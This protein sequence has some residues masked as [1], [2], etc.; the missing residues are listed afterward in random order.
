M[1]GLES[2]MATDLDQYVAPR[3]KADQPLQEDI[4]ENKFE[5][6][7][8]TKDKEK[9]IH[10]IASDTFA[11][12]SEH[13]Y[14]EETPL[15]GDI[16]RAP[17]SSLGEDYEGH[18]VVHHT[19]TNNEK[20]IDDEPLLDEVYINRKTD[21]KDSIATKDM[22]GLESFMATDLDQC[23]AARFEA[24]QPQQEDIIEE[25]VEQV[26]LNKKEKYIH[27]ITSD[28]VVFGTEH[29]YFEETVTSG[30][31]NRT[32]H[33]SY[34]EDDE[35]LAVGSQINTDNEESTVD[36]PLLEEVYISRNNDGKAPTQAKDMSGLESF[37]AADLD[38]CPAR[39]FEAEQPE[40]EDIIEEHFEQIILTKDKKKDIHQI[41]S[42]EDVFGT[43]HKYFEETV[44][45]EDRKRT[46]YSSFGEDDEILVVGSQMNTDDEKIIVDRPLLEEVHM[47]RTTDNQRPTGVKGMSESFMATD[48]GQCLPTRFVAD[49]PQQEKIIEENDEKV[50]LTKDKEKYIHQ[51]TS[52]EVVFGAEHKYYKETVIS[53]DRNR[54]PCSSLGEDDEGLAV[55]PQM[56]T[57]DEGITVDEPLLE[58]HISRHSDGKA[59]TQAKDMSGLESFMATDLDQC[60]ATRFVADQ[61]QQERNIEEH[62]EHIILTKDKNKDIHQ[63]TS[64]EVLFGTEHKYFEETV[65][66]GEG[67]RTP[68]SSLGEDDELL[69]VGSQMSTDDEE[70]S[71]DEPIFKEVHIS[72]KSDSKASIATKDMSGLES[73]MA[74]DLD[75]CPATRFVADQPQQDDI[76]EEHFQQIILT[77]DKNKDIHQITS[78]EDVFGTEH[79]YFEETVISGEGNRTPYS[80][81]GEYD[82][83]LAVG[84]QMNTDNEGITMDE[85]L[86]EKVH[87]S[88]NNDGKV[89]TQAKDM[90]GLESFMATGLDQCLATRFVADQPQ[91]EYIIEEHFEQP[92]LTK[93]KDKGIPQITSDEVV[94]GI[95][96]QYFEET[97]T[98]EDQNRTP[99]SSLGEDDELLA[100]GLQMNTDDEKIT[101]DEPLLEEVHISRKHDSKASIAAKDMSGLESYMAAGLDQCLATRVVAYHPQQEDIIEENFEQTIL[102]K[103]KDKGMPQI[104]SDEVVFGTEHKYFEETVTS[105]DQNRTPHSSLGEDDELLA[106]GPQMNTDD[107]EITV[108]EPLLEEVHISRKHDS[109]ASIAAKDMS[110]LESYMATGLDQCLATS[111]VADQPQQEHI[112]EENFEQTILTKDEDKGIPQITSDEVVFGT[113][114]KYFEETVTSEDQNRTPH[115]S[116]GEDDELLAV[117]PQMNTDEEITVDEPLLEE[118]HISRKHDSKASIAA[119]DMSG[120][121]SYMAT[122]LDQCLATRVVAYQPQ[123]E[124]IIEENFEQ[125]ILT[126]DKD[127]GIPQI[128]SDEVVF[129][130]EH[131]YFEETVTSEDQNRTPHSSLGE[132]D[133]LLAVGPQMNTDDK[134]ITVDEPLLEEVH[135]SRKNDSK[136]SIAAKDMSGLESYMATGLDQCL[137]TTFVADQPQQEHIVEENFEQTILTKDKDKGIPQITSDEVVFGTEHK[138]FEETVTSEDQNRTPHSSLGEDDELLAVG[139]QMN[140]DD[141]EITVNEPLLEEVHISRKHDSKASIAAKDMSGLESYMATGLDQCLATRFV[142]YQPQQEDIIEENFEQ[143]ILTKDKD[144]GIPQITSDEVVFGTEHKYFEETVTSEDQNRTPHSS[145]G[146][147]DELLAVGPQMNTDDEEITVDEPLLEKV[148]ISRKNDSKAS[149]AAKDMSGLESYMATDL[150]QCLATRVVVDRPQQ[151]YIIEENFE[152]II[153][154]KNKEKD[155]HQIDPDDCVIS[156]EH[157]YFEETV[158]SGDRNKTIHSS[159]SE[160]DEEFALGPQMNTDDEENTMDEPLL[161]EDHISRKKYSKAS[162]VVKDMSGLQSLMATDLDQCLATRFVADQPLQEDIIE[163]NFEQ[164]IL[165]KDKEKDI[166]QIAPDEVVLSTE[167][168][169]FDESVK[170]R[171]RNRTPYSSFGE[172]EELSVGPQINTDS[173]DNTVDEPLFVEVHISKKKDSEATIAI[174]D[175]SGLES[176]M[177]TDLDQCL[178]TRFVAQKETE[179]ARSTFEDKH[180][181]TTEGPVTEEWVGLKS[182][183][184]L[185]KNVRNMSGMISLLKSDL[186]QD[187]LDRPVAHETPQEDLI[188]E[189]FQK[190]QKPSREE[191]NVEDKQD[192]QTQMQ[193]DMADGKEKAMSGIMSV[194]GSDLEKGFKDYHVATQEDTISGAAITTQLSGESQMPINQVWIE[195]KPQQQEFMIKQDGSGMLSLL[196]HDLD[197]CLKE[198]PVVIQ[199]YPEEDAIHERCRQVVIPK[200]SDR[201][202]ST[203]SPVS[204]NG[205]S[206]FSCNSESTVKM[207]KLNETIGE[208]HNDYD[209]TNIDAITPN[210]PQRPTDFKNL[211]T[212]VMDDTVKELYRKDSLE[213]SP[214]AEDTSSKRSPDSIEPS[215]TRESL[216]PD[217]LEGSPTQSEKIG[218]GITHKAAVYEDYASQLKACLDYDT[219]ICINDFTPDESEN[220]TQMEGDKYSTL[221]EDDNEDYSTHQ[222]FT[223]EEEMFKM[224]ARIKTFDEMEQ[225]ARTNRDASSFEPSQAGISEELFPEKDESLKNRESESEIQDNEDY[226]THFYSGVTE[227]LYPDDDLKYNPML[228]NGSD[229]LTE[230]M[231]VVFAKETKN[232]TSSCVYSVTLNEDADLAEDQK[233]LDKSPIQSPIDDI[234]PDQFQFKKGKLFEMTRGGAIDLTR[235]ADEEAEGYAFFQI[236]GCPTEVVSEEIGEEQNTFSTFDKGYLAAKE[237]LQKTGDDEA[238]TPKPRTLFP[239]SS[240]KSKSEK[241]LSETDLGSSTEVQLGSPSGLDKLN[242]IQSDD[243]GFKGHGANYLD[244]TIAD[245]QSNANVVYQSAYSKQNYDSS[246]SSPD[247]DE[248]DQCSVIEMSSSGAQCSKKKESEPD[249]VTKKTDTSMKRRTRSETDG[250]PSNVSQKNSRS[251]SE[252]T[253]LTYESNLSIAKPILSTK[254]KHKRIHIGEAEESSVSLDTDDIS[255]SSRKSPDSVIFTYDMPASSSSDSDPVTAVRRSSS[256]VAVFE[257]RPTWDDKVETQMQ[258]ITDDQTS[259]C[260]AGMA[261]FT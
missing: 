121:E 256:A 78:D 18:A 91:Q 42:D 210:I 192:E 12:S 240:D 211:D 119:K 248:E 241:Y 142:A 90:S 249:L 157:K 187:L 69:A 77:K 94:F 11:F 236:E 10:P 252:S 130:T 215:P 201:D 107:E 153:L 76:I 126:K 70:I 74:A 138:Y 97:V 222:Q 228:D 101:V 58:V 120:L 253:Q 154:T 251:C 231:A 64:D 255:S 178:A 199:G 66:C 105:E 116:L 51:I 189:Q 86:L 202:T 96:H 23:P 246:D 79:K 209:D 224:A 145:L 184:Q 22:S 30:D 13:K 195:R 112:I 169:Y 50:I 212:V 234:T 183:Y 20:V 61:P 185:S 179:E 32:P 80:S 132:D 85:P 26:V 38:E 193:N 149:I 177:A 170:S 46:P 197:Q 44:I 152:Q 129:G 131:K 83:G 232:D 92:I 34:G 62:F 47:S 52:D 159:F 250:G 181:L 163:E 16:I 2:F 238:P 14:F 49:Q 65:I 218:E 35:P 100:V 230:P 99:H 226:M 134:E 27:E 166:H 109:K 150:D 155:I 128:I 40:Q 243:E 68:Y 122:G 214:V 172:D 17:L 5:Q 174:K 95:E 186:D 233:T 191:T 151:E 196:N 173:E 124:D 55:G 188:Q 200:Y 254:Q 141:E 45:S 54:T 9:D 111:F 33:S 114:H 245:L 208:C 247:E 237:I 57:G 216:C 48:L 1:S 7:I 133:E 158:K 39:K 72:R 93:D 88:R 81:L 261:R 147:D 190:V 15:S 71:V 176:L 220:F 156:T 165:T 117:G 257:S 258:R 43:E 123:Q 167:H 19:K 206:H 60:P 137:A 84:P 194:L 143:T 59:P 4:I 160:D 31:Q 127:K 175:M 103:D 135:I 140:T 259:E 161:E 21:S 37:M 56:N 162:T 227:H 87:N 104:T 29:T 144:K 221:Q 28:E 204:P 207:T 180:Y 213:A 171:D 8:L 67:S 106:V 229:S 235:S 219:N 164:T 198:E 82:E 102:T 63:I 115:S 24:D 110:G 146:E 205:N 25:N 113:E 89:S 118:V 139:P 223:P 36:E 53:G 225:E 125:T 239:P 242:L 73:Y 203:F 148:H 98:S 244:S 217:S 41:T 3:F 108:D 260:T 75:Q 182:S 168:K 136:A 6:I